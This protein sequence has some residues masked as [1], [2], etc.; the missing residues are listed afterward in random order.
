MPSRGCKLIQSLWRTVKSFKWSSERPNGECHYGE[1]QGD[2]LKKWR[3]KTTM[4][5]S[6]PAIGCIPWENHN[7]KRHMHPSVTAA[8]FTITQTWTQTR[9]PQTGEWIKKIWYVDS[10]EYYSAMRRNAF[11]SVQMRWMNLEALI[12]SE[13]SQKERQISYINAYM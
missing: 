2:S 1:H 12:Q 13:V 6:N 4:W 5:P 8:L 7:W 11:E 10:M 9:C 3:K